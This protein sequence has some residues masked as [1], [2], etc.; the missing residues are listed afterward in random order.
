MMRLRRLKWLL[1]LLV[2]LLLIPLQAGQAASRQVKTLQAPLA[3]KIETYPYQGKKYYIPA[4]YLQYHQKKLALLT[5]S[6]DHKGHVVVVSYVGAG[7]ETAKT[8]QFNGQ[9]R[10]F[11]SLYPKK[12]F[13]AAYL[14]SRAQKHDYLT[15]IITAATQTQ[16]VVNPQKKSYQFTSVPVLYQFEGMNQ[17]TGHPVR[18]QNITRYRQTKQLALT[19]SKLNAPQVTMLN[20]SGQRASLPYQTADT[21]QL[22]VDPLGIFQLE[23]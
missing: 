14:K 7:K 4:A 13:M 1:F 6:N 22:T 3:G 16:P 23:N 10:Y 12:T 21:R 5:V 8:Y 17:T 9:L 15:N 11:A 20:Q 18:K 2:G 19:A